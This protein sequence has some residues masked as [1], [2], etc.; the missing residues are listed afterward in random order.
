M[1]KWQLTSFLTKHIQPL[2]FNMYV[3]NR[4]MQLHKNYVHWNTETP[5][6]Y[7]NIHLIWHPTIWKTWQSKDWRVCFS[8]ENC[9]INETGRSQEHV[10]KC[11]KECLYINNYSNSWP[12]F[13]YSTNFFSYEGFRNTEE[14]P[15]D[16]DLAHGDIQILWMVVQFK[17]SSSNEKL[18]VRT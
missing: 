1:T 8:P 4:F 2:T 6:T 7:S 17:Y 3:I 9:F 18:P 16:P 12:L 10:Q 11:L 13:S 14:N 5:V 15:N